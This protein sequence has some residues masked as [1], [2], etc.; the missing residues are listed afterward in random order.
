MSEKELK[1]WKELKKD[2]QEIRELN[3][4]NY[5]INIVLM[6]NMKNNLLKMRV[7]NLSVSISICISV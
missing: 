1:Q 5:N 6:Q 2:L 4:I 7:N 3:N